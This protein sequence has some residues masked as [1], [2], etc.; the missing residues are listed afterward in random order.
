M[1]GGRGGGE[2]ADFLSLTNKSKWRR[3]GVLKESLCSLHERCPPVDPVLVVQVR[4]Q[5]DQQAS[6]GQVA[7]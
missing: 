4:A 7:A 2:L 3:D 1:G 5:V 6:D